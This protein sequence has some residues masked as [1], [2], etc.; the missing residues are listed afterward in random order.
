MSKFEDMINTIQLGNCYELIKDIPDK[1]IDLIYI[2]IPYDFEGNGGGCCFGSK[3][4]DYHKEYEKVSLN[5]EVSPLSKR[6]AKHNDEMQNI[7]YGIDYKILDELCRTM[8]YIYIYIY[9]V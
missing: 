5:T 3:K 8:K 4:R 2:D 1:S 7:A 6:K 9:M